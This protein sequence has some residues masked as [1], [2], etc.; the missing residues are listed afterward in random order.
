MKIENKRQKSRTAARRIDTEVVKRII[1]ILHDD[2]NEKKTKISLKAH[3]S[4]DKCL[5]YLEWLELMG[6]IRK[7]NDDQD[8]ELINLTEKGN[9]LY[10]K[11]SEDR[12]SITIEDS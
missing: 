11:Y 9:E 10:L 3:L 6:L 8:S 2:G 4:Y 1:T 12:N 5:S 7:E